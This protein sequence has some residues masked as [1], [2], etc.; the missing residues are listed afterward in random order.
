MVDLPEPILPLFEGLP[1]HCHLTMRATSAIS[2]GLSSQ[3]CTLVGSLK[4]SFLQARDWGSAYIL[5]LFWNFH[6]KGEVR[7][8]EVRWVQR[9]NKYKTTNY[10]ALHFTR[11]S[12]W[13]LAHGRCLR[14]GSR[15]LL[16]ITTVTQDWAQR[17][18]KQFICLVSVFCSISLVI[19]FSKEVSSP[20][21]P[22]SIPNPAESVQQ[23]TDLWY[24]KPCS[25]LVLAHGE[26]PGTQAPGEEVTEESRKC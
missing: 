6:P 11:T 15:E 1:L 9:K 2:L 25:I 16:C 17:K 21:L 24:Q 5:I 3:S 23:S 10:W 22:V 7:G 26:G 14:R 8:R 4:A 12:S 19:T 13:W 20:T 18:G